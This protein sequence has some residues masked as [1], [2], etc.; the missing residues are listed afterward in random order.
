MDKYDRSA[1]GYHPPSI[2]DT[3]RQLIAAGFPFCSL[4]ATTQHLHP[5]HFRMSTWKRYC[6]PGS[7]ARCGMRG[8]GGDGTA[9]NPS[10]V[11][12]REVSGVSTNLTPS[13]V[14]RVNSGSD[15]GGCSWNQQDGL[16]AITVGRP[17]I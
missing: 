3:R 15:I 8:G 6:S 12:G 7:G 16:H 11:C 13:S 1:R 4:Q 9:C 10:R 5:M 2:S 17:P 14:A